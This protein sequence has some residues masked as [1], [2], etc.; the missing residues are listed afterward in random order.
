[1]ARARKHVVRSAHGTSWSRSLTAA[2]RADIVAR[3]LDDEPVGRIAAD[4]GVNTPQVQA[5]MSNAGVGH[6]PQRH[7]GL[8]AEGVALKRAIGE[9][10]GA[11]FAEGRP[12]R[13]GEISERLSAVGV[14]AGDDKELWEVLE[15]LL[16]EEVLFK[17]VAPW[18]VY[19]P[20]FGGFGPGAY[21]LT[22]QLHARH[23]EGRVHLVGDLGDSRVAAAC[24]RAHQA[25]ARQYPRE[26]KRHYDAALA[27]MKVVDVRRVS[28][29]AVE[30]LGLTVPTCHVLWGH[31]VRTVGDL[32]DLSR[33]GLR[34]VEGFNPGM[35]REVQTALRAV[36]VS[37]PDASRAG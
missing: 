17:V 34:A 4:Y 26:W 11:L 13:I 21:Y 14:Q 5:L 7:G 32:V 27:Q 9:Q 2:Q 29:V 23:L 28:G 33:T 6:P 8:A 15:S 1:M 19:W 37:L 36:G 24:Q 10:V 25:L 30:A 16:D 20:A 22:P 18:A 31:G 3:Y 35:V 12:L